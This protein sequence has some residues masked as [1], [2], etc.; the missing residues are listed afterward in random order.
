MFKKRDKRSD[1]IE[2]VQLKSINNNYELDIITSI[3]DDNKIPYIVKE[4][5][6]GGYMRII[7]ADTSIYR[8][9]ILVEKS[10]YEHAKD[11]LD[12]IT[13]EE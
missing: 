1:E 12:Q 5:G 4:H 3:L 7:G 9:D 13:F 6:A 11:L 2:L 10:T 8:T